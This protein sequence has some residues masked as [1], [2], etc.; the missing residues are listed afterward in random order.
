MD[1]IVTIRSGGASTVTSVPQ[2]VTVRGY[3]TDTSGTPDAA[4]E[5]LFSGTGAEGVDW[6]EQPTSPAIPAARSMPRAGDG[7][8]FIVPR[9][10]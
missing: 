9:R 3:D 6:L 2:L 10:W 5:V 1:L 7:D 8:R 4:A